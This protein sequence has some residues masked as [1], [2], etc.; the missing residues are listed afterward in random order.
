M[1]DNVITSISEIAQKYN[2]DKAVLF[3]SRARGDNRFNSDYD[4]AIYGTTSKN[5][6]MLWAAFEEIPTLLKIDIVFVSDNTSPQL[7]ENI[8]KDGKIIY[9]KD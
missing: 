5:Q 3:G 2:A 1:T 4:I 6:P 9:A 8:R 7:V